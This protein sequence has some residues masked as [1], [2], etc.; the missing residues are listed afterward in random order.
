VSIDI[1]I[2]L[3]IMI[4]TWLSGCAASLVFW[5]RDRI[6]STISFLAA[7]S[8]SLAGL[9]CS[10]SLLLSGIAIESPLPSMFPLARFALRLDSLGA[11]FLFILS[12]TALAT[13][14]YSF[15][16]CR[17]YIGRK[18]VAALGALFNLFLVSM[19]LVIVANNVL[20]FLIVWELMSLISALLVA[21]EVSFRSISGFRPRIRKLHQMFPL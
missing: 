12:L 10:I 7:A 20:M 4:A 15:G 2:L 6:A 5:K 9:F 1:T 11:F 21:F 18:S 19:A 14:I 16:Y 13:S 17:E 8:G 3:K